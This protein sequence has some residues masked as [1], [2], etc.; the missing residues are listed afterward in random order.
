MT[1][2]RYVCNTDP[3]DDEKQTK[4]VN[5]GVEKAKK[6]LERGLDD[7]MKINNPVLRKTCLFSLID[8]FAQEYANYPVRNTKKA[9]CDFV[10][11]YQ[12]KYDY[13][14]A[15]DPVTLLYDY[16][17]KIKLVVKNPKLREFAPELC[18]EKPEIS[19]DDFGS[20]D[21]KRLTEIIHSKAAHELQVLIEQNEDKQQYNGYLE[22]HK[23]INLIYKMRSKAVH[24]MSYLGTGF[25]ESIDL[26]EP[27]YIDVMRFYKNVDTIVKDNVYEL[28]IPTN[29]IYELTKNSIENYLEDCLHKKR[30]PFQNNSNCKRSVF[31]T[32]R[33]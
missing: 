6:V 22:R 8:S 14:L 16:E 20:L 2:K 32:W 19:F 13:L 33:D 3:W 4:Y 26:V 23:L 17:P 10:I 30:H 18:R 24:E 25:E 5:K 21:E 28:I 12:N 15:V 31:I 1:N 11:K 7:A 27:Y 9:F 29:F